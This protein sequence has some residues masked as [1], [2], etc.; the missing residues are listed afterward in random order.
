MPNQ[1]LT[2]LP[3]MDGLSAILTQGDEKELVGGIGIEPMAP[4]V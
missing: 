2:L 4:A 1:H 3:G